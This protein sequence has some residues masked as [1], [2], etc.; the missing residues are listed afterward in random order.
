MS[1]KLVICSPQLGLS[2]ESNLGGEVYDREI[3]SQLCNHGLKVIVILPKKKLHFVHKNLKVYYL[4]FCC[5]WPPYLFN[6]FVIPYLFWLYKKEKFNILRIHSPYF[7]GLG[8]LFFKIF[9]P[10]I[11]LIAVYHH[12]EGRFLYDLIDKFTIR[13]W[14][15]LL[16]D[17]RFTKKE[18]I[19]T[20]KI[21]AKRIQQT[22]LGVNPHFVPKEKNQKLINKYR[23]KN[24]KVLLFLGGLKQRK[25]IDFLFHLLA[26]IKYSNLKL[27]ICGSGTLGGKLFLKVKNLGLKD[28]VVFT[29]FI[30]EKEKVDYYNLADI[31]LSPSLKEGFG[32]TVLEAA[33]CG[34][35]AIVSKTSSLA[36]IVIN[37]QTGYLA[38]LNNL[39]DWKT[40][41]EKLLA[42]ESLRKK[43]GQAARKFSLQFTWKIS[44]KKQIGLYRRLLATNN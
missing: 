39:C 44:A 3:L 11:F 25:N 23:L 41:T 26:K 29:G 5:V 1:K 24:K 30:P 32:L 18:I 22:Y 13:R 10:K 19:N 7:V 20:Y 42:N 35:P 15:S 40:K 6:L 31:F 38:Q 14:D 16:V 4:P 17:S 43:I 36:E 8:G 37:G 12:L 21:E 28:K 9:H 27:L 33:S 34:I 2:P